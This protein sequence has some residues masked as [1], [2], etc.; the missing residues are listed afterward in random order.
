MTRIQGTNSVGNSQPTSSPEESNPLGDVQMQDFLE[1]MIAELQNQDPLNP[2]DNAQML[3]QIS[4]IREIGA[5][6]QLQSTLEGLALSQNLSGASGLLG[7]YVHALN[8]KA[9]FVTG[10]VD[11]VS[12]E[13]EDVILHVGQ[14]RINS[15]NISQIATEEDALS[16]DEEA[17]STP[18]NE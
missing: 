18:T 14:H 10:K 9:D 5:T 3:Q 1:L 7:K 15:R 6:D 13:E 16:T 17:G 2:M 4:Q 8:D 12:V 11:R